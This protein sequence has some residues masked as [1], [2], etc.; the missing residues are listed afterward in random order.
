MS[1]RKN[2]AEFPRDKVILLMDDHI[3]TKH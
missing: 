2:I 1:I 3:H